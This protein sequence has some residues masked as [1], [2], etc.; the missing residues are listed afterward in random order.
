MA[1]VVYPPIDFHPKPPSAFGFG[2]ALSNPAVGWA[3]PNLTLGHTN[4]GPFQQLASSMNQSSPVRA[5]KRRYEPEEEENIGI[6][7]RGRDESMDRSPTPERPK[8]AA[9]KRARV[10]DA[11]TKEDLKK[12]GKESKAKSE[13]DEVDVGV[14]LGE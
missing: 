13:A 7:G 1:N 8:R 11:G 12:G 14:L 4:P 10:V 9:P 3:S 6:G 5:Q 2:F